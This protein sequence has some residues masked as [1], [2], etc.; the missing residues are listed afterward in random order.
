MKK[1]G[2]LLIVIF[3]LI[4][5]TQ[6][7]AA[8]DVS[9]LI[10]GIEKNDNG[11]SV[12][13]SV[14]NDSVENIDKVAIVACYDE[15]NRL[16][17]QKI[18]AVKMVG[19]SKVSKSMS[20]ETDGTVHKVKGYIWD[21]IINMKPYTDRISELKVSDNKNKEIWDFGDDKFAELGV[22]AEPKTVD[23]L[24]INYKTKEIKIHSNN[25]GGTGLYLYGGGNLSDC[26]VTFKVNGPCNIRVYA[27]S[28][29]D[30]ERTVKIAD[31]NNNAL[32][33][34]PVSGSVVVND[35]QYTGREEKISVFSTASGMYIYRIEV[36]YNAE[37][38]YS[39]MYVEDYTQLIQG[40]RMAENQGG[41][42]IYI[43]TDYMECDR[44]LV[45]SKSN[46]NV[47]ITGA[48]GYNPVL[49]YTPY[50]SKHIG[51]A[52]S[53]GNNAIKITGSNYIVRNMIIEKA[54]GGGIRFYG[55]KSGNN[56]VENIVTRYNSGGGIGIFNG[57]YNNTVQYCDSYR[58]CDV[59][60]IGGNADGFQAGVNAGAGNI[61]INC[62]A[63][64][65]SDDGY[66]NFANYNDV[67]YIDC[68]CW[69]NGNPEI[70]IGK[71]D[72]KNGKPLDKNML[73]IQLIMEYDPEFENNYNNKK[74]KYTNDKFINITLDDV[75]QPVSIGE[76]I[77]TYWAGNPNGFK[78]GSG[79]S[80]H[81]PLVGPEATRTL[82]NC[83]A[84][85]HISKGVDRNNGLFTLDLKNV[86][87]FDNKK[88]Y[89]TNGTVTVNFENAVSFGGKTADEIENGTSVILPAA[90]EQIAKRG[91][92]KAI[93]QSIVDKVNNNEIPGEV[94]FDVF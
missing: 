48:E 61:F 37:K 91:K 81:G 78:L 4:M 13:Y 89:W 67:T 71:K 41:G 49:D 55:D 32:T 25:I 51:Q 58:N 50:L 84:F 22:I 94:K 56:L 74:L 92:I 82:V 14:Y 18:D 19:S 39:N 5:C 64:E 75:I 43:Q 65:N 88:N 69:D 73:L 45:L 54:P 42:T 29:T 47:T 46:A 77:S 35:Y 40:V 3:T 31:S 16:I 6:I 15:S 23:G 1:A 17:S 8:E 66:D 24:T 63:W 72:Y 27:S 68:V 93:A 76:F 38:R 87:S 11:Y 70:F 83:I 36:N 80:K 2:Y 62:R 53:V 52:G 33:T 90:Q 34:F 30:I 26:S 44:G 59:L 21:D 10:D 86:I 7:L 12:D 20:I 28:T 60:T 9:V 79:D 57:A 85:E